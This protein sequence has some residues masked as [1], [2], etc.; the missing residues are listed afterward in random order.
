MCLFA[1]KGSEAHKSS[2]LLSALTGTRTAVTNVQHV[3][4]IKRLLGSKN[5]RNT[6]NKNITQLYTT[7]KVR[8]FIF[9]EMQTVWNPE[10]LWM[11]V[12]VTAPSMTANRQW[13]VQ[14]RQ[15]GGKPVSQ[16]RGLMLIRR[17]V[18]TIT[19]ELLITKG[20]NPEHQYAHTRVLL[21]Q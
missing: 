2:V 7:Y 3:S 12:G 15:N 9:S 10:A 21:L 6:N 11:T 18:E 8:N 5:L 13:S 19:M 1:I 20:R 17:N 16:H 4:N 14:Y